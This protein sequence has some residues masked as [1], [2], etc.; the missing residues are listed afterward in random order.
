MSQLKLPGMI[1][2]GDDSWE[3]INLNPDKIRGDIRKNYP[4]GNPMHG[5]TLALQNDYH[6][7]Q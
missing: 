7:R 3:I 1:I 6:A 5:F 2:Y 4:L